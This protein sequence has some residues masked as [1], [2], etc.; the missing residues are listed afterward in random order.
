MHSGIFNKDIIVFGCGNILF[1]DD[2]FGPAVI[3][4]LDENFKIPEPVF[5]LDVGTSIRDCL[6]DLLLVEEKPSKIFVLDAVQIDGRK[7]GE[8]FEMDIVGIPK[9]KASDFSLHQC[10]TTNL[11]QELNTLGGVNVQVLC[12]Q[13]NYV[14]EEVFFGLSKE[15]ENSIPEACKW[16]VEN[17]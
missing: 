14:P 8:L 17:F 4:Y 5:T 6:F 9:A 3:D 2:G 11:L 13:A 1:G 15:V 10:P 12:I 7:P 16:L